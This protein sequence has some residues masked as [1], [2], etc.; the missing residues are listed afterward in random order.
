MLDPWPQTV[1]PQTRLQEAIHEKHWAERRQVI[2][3]LAS[4]YYKDLQRWATQLAACGHT[5]RFWIDPDA[6]S[7]RP[8]MPRCK[9]RLC[10]WC[11]KARTIHVADQLEAA[12]KKFKRPR[13]MVLTVRSNERPLADQL[14]AMRDAFKRLRRKAEWLRKVVGGVYVIEITL[15]LKTRKWHPHIHL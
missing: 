15:N 2:Q 8:W 9:H 4:G 6:G 14:R 1:A 3:A 5:V 11:A 10:P 7:V 12:M 13:L